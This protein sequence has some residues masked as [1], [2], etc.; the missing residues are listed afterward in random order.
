[1]MDMRERHLKKV[2][3][4]REEGLRGLLEAQDKKKEAKKER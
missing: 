3:R 1:M 4:D 2:A